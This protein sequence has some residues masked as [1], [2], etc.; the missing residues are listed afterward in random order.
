MNMKCLKCKKEHNGSVGSGKY[1]SIKCYR[2][3]KRPNKLTGKIISCAFCGKAAYK[4]KEQLKH[5][6]SFCSLVCANK[7]QARNKE[8]YLAPKD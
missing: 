6:H 3:S 8:L 5:K 7:F 2:K 4:S 1:C